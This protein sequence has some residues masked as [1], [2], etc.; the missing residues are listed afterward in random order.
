MSRPAILI[1]AFFALFTFTTAAKYHIA[2][3]H[4]SNVQKISADLVLSHLYLSD[5]KLVAYVVDWD[6]PKSIR[7]DHL[8]HIAYAFAEPNENGDL[9]SY[10]GSNLKS[11]KSSI[12]YNKITLIY[13]KSI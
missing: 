10:S 6:I 3:K 8:D 9:E 11:G 13:T 12:I 7:W 2:H 4:S 5:H 1:V